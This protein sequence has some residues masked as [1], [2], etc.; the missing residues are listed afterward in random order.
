[1]RLTCIRGGLNA[2]FEAPNASFLAGFSVSTATNNF[3]PPT[4][5]AGRTK[6]TIS[7][8]PET[9][10]ASCA[11]VVVMLHTDPYD[12]STLPWHVAGPYHGTTM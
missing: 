11:D 6:G 9:P 1:M 3:V 7:T 10:S 4:L 2:T 8:G 5:A 12:L